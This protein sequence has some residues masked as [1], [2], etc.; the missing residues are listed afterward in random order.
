MN[1]ELRK[2]ALEADGWMVDSKGFLHHPDCP[3]QKTP[4]HLC[5]YHSGRN[6]GVIR[7]APAVESDPGVSETWFLAW[8]EKNGWDWEL[9]RAPHRKGFC[10]I[11]WSNDGH[12]HVY[13]GTTCSEARAK[14]VVKAG[15]KN[16]I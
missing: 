15:R 4:E 13:D 11:L 8:C 6:C 9:K 16:A 3:V 14:A 5:G 10:V 7:I 12:G 2:A 1:L